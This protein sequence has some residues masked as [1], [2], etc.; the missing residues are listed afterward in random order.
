MNDPEEF[1]RQANQIV[2]NKIED[3]LNNKDD[4]E[5]AETQKKIYLSHIPNNFKVLFAYS[6]YIRTSDKK[7]MTAEIL[8]NSYM[9][10]EHRH[11]FSTPLQLLK[12]MKLTALGRST[13]ARDS[14]YKGN[15]FAVVQEII[16]KA[17]KEPK[18]AA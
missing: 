9:N 8:I 1:S 15:Y 14:R 7:R 18:L 4:W 10:E 11:I 12:T 13:K 2:R 6:G 5:Q 16:D 3:H 17:E